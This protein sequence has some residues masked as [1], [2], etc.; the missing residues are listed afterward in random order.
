MWSSQGTLDFNR[1]ISYIASVGYLRKKHHGGGG[2]LPACTTWHTRPKNQAL[3]NTYAYPNFAGETHNLCCRYLVQA[4]VDVNFADDYGSQPLDM[5]I[6]KGNSEILSIL[7][8]AGAM[9]SV[10]QVCTNGSKPSLGDG[11]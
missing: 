2:N 11:S 3:K 6:S 9:R 8:A 10:N 4:G 1:W 5:A 7:K